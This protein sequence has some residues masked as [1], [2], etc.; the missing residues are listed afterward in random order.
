MRI[1]RLDFLEKLPRLCTAKKEKSF[2]LFQVGT[3]NPDIA[4]RLGIDQKGSTLY[5]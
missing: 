4:S 5:E 2:S 1:L 3:L